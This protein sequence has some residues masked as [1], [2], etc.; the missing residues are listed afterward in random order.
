M[1]IRRRGKQA[2][3]NSSSIRS[4]ER[5]TEGRKQHRAKEGS[6]WRRKGQ[7]DN[8]HE[9]MPGCASGKLIIRDG[10][11]RPTREGLLELRNRGVCSRAHSHP[12]RNQPTIS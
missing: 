9:Y 8:H 4:D 5:F 2:N 7:G 6:A 12:Q 3:G 10:K 1:G 11:R